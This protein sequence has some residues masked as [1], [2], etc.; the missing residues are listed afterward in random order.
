MGVGGRGRRDQGFL[1]VGLDQRYAGGVG[2]K[3][4]RGWFI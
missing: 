4:N 1:H 3:G 2:G